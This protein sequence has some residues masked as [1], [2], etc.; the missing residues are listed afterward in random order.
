MTKTI[1]SPTR[2]KNV[3]T[4]PELEYAG[5]HKDSH[6]IDNAIAAFIRYCNIRNLTQ[7]S[8]ISYQDTLK[9][10]K[11][12]VTEHEIAEL[13]DITHDHI[14]EFILS[15]RREGL[16]DATVDKYIRSWRAFFNFLALEGYISDNPFNRVYKM[17]SEKRIIETL[18]KQQLKALFDA[19]DKS[20]FTGYRDYVIMLLFLDSMIRVSEAEGILLQNIDWNNR[21]I[22]VYGKGRKE[23]YVPF[24]RTVERHLKQYIDIRGLLDHD[25]LFVNIDN[26]PIKTRGIQ[27]SISNHGKRALIEGVRVSPHSLRHTGAKM[28]VMNGGDPLSLQKILGHTSLAMVTNYVALFATDVSTKHDR[29]SPLEELLKNK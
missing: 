10:L 19:P 4:A 9:I 22:K 2:R 13:K 6:Q 5:L 8:I 15:K 16:V 27:E 23:R 29:H 12:I 11:R 3:V 20:K 21:R 14:H 17:K 25:Y 1:N 7:N 18:S 28:Y 24:Q 26:T